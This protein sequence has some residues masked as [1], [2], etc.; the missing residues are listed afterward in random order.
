MLGNNITDTLSLNINM[1]TF[2]KKKNNNSLLDAKNSCN[3]ILDNCCKIFMC[4]L[5]VKTC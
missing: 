4:K 2:K 1:Y 3:Y 5:N